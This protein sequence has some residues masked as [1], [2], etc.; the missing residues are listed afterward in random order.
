MILNELYEYYG[1]W[2]ELCRELKLGNNTYQTWRRQGYIP[3]QTQLLI[4]NR[5][6]GRFKADEKHG[7]PKKLKKE[8]KAR[9]V[10]GN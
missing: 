9:E 1:T 4:E 10:L 8:L 5:S 2:T 3:F 6:R 7:R